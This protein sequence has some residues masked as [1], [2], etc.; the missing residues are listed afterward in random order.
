MCEVAR[1]YCGGKYE[2][3]VV[4]VLRNLLD[5]V[6]KVH[7]YACIYTIRNSTFEKYGYELQLKLQ[8]KTVPCRCCQ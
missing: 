5:R 3:N 7:I 4:S 8:E 1:F 6:A 2:F